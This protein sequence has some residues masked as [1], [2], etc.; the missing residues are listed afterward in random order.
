MTITSGLPITTMVPISVDSMQHSGS[1][2]YSLSIFQETD[3]D[4]ALPYDCFCATFGVCTDIHHYI[5]LKQPYQTVPF[6]MDFPA[7][8]LETGKCNF[9]QQVMTES[10]L[11]ILLLAAVT[12]SFPIE[13][14]L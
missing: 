9:I 13:K 4:L 11:S 1:S 8:L 10:T 7:R 3:T 2:I 6:T 14:A 5:L 12:A